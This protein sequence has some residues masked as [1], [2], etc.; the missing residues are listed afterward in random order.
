MNL[1]ELAEAGD[2]PGVF[3]ELRALAPEQ[4]AS[5]APA[6]AA[7]FEA[8][9][10]GAWRELTEER[11]IALSAAQ[12]G[13]QIT[14]R[15]AA[16]CVLRPKF[17]VP[18]KSGWMRDV[19]DMYPAEWQ[20]ELV[21]RIGEQETGPTMDGV[22]FA[23]ADSLVR[24]TGCPVPTSDAYINAWL[25][26]C[27]YEA[28]SLDV[29]VRRLRDNHCAATLLPLVVARPGVQ[30]P[31]V[32][33]LAELA[34]EGLLDRA[35]LVRRVFAEMADPHPT[36]AVMMLEG[37]ALTPEEHARMTPE[38]VAFVELL[39]ARLLQD[40]TRDE[41]A[42]HLKLLRAL[43]LA[44]A[45][46]A[47]FL[48][49]HVAMLDLS[50]PV[51]TYGQEVLI[52]LDEAGLLE[53]D[54][55]TET[56]ERVL[57]RAEKKLVRAQLSWLDRVARRARRTPERVDQVLVDAAV[58]FQ[59]RDTVLAERALGLVARHLKAAG[60]AVL[61]ELRTAAGALGP[62]HAAR[63]AELFGPP[64]EPEDGTAA[65]PYA[66]VLPDA[67]GPRP[68][69]GPVE[70][71]AEVAPEVAAVLAREDDVVAFE[72]ALDGLVRHA[73]LDRATLSKAL[74]PV[75]R[76]EPHHSRDCTPTDLYDV[77]AAVRGDEPREW[78]FRVRED[79]PLSKLMDHTSPATPPG[80]LLK[81]R[82]SEAI[83][84]IESGT[85]PF[86]LALPTHANGALDA[87]TLV[88]RIAELERLGVTPAPVDMAQALLR[89]TPT[90]DEEV[91]R[92]AG[93]LRSDAG[94][95]LARWLREGGL[96][97]QDSTPP[98]WPAADPTSAPANWWL[99]VDPGLGHVPPLPP[100]AAAVVGTYT[101]ER[102]KTGPFHHP[103]AHAAPFWMAQL[104]HHRD[105]MAAR[106]EHNTSAHLLTCV[107]ECG[108]PAGYAT[109]WQ[110][111]RRMG[112]ARDAP[113]DAMLL[114]A[115]QGQLDSA[116]L[117]GQ[118]Q[119]LLRLGV[120]KPNRI[121]DAL[122]TAAETGAYATVW[123]VLEAVLPALLRDTPV[124]GAGA[125][126]AL[127]VECASRCGAKGRIPEVEAVAARAGSSQTV[128]NARLLR[129]VLG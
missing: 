128:K 111:A 62:E 44:P 80:E 56:C 12:L 126:L 114:L 43:A 11:R 82:L 36:I 110:I 65:E 49:D 52:A 108:G 30:L 75:M 88:E 31:Q 25:G 60:G 29:L 115:A 42:P 73:R 76:K 67:S 79:H 92:A 109:H 91:R 117:A 61:P 89:V 45:E 57:L 70:T 5:H 40:G 66:E 53:D 9:D 6:L 103:S 105:E 96:P 14:P 51:A 37:L 19:V 58:A 74:E 125:F 64:E 22:P 113:V 112:W 46:N 23:L 101:P 83:E 94:A 78:D 81:A 71:A 124:R 99:P 127:A 72:R 106:I 95:R 50:L 119:A 68:I 100:V 10:A 41:T 24:A 28:R 7:R 93:E 26:Q 86:L 87:A 35:A 69:P 84:L 97:R 118:L 34:A 48:R 33:V 8:T 116:L 16:A 63:A 2:V 38:R 15:D 85:Q 121:T 32:S 20:A 104:P 120:G 27:R 90:A 4:R 13:C 3:R 98:E 102:G 59:H 18:A 21:A 17:R 123:S 77:A 39:L 1:I 107:V 55:R 122:R 54:V 47:P 129:D